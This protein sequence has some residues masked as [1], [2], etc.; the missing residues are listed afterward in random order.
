MLAEGWKQANIAK[1]L[2]ITPGRVT[3]IK[4]EIRAV[5]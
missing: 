1:E 2:G 3:Q 4:H 5:A